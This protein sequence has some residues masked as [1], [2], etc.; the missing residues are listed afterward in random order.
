MEPASTAQPQLRVLVVDDDPLI[1]EAFKRLLEPS[2]VVFAQSAV[3]ALGRIQAG[4][5]FDA[6]LCDINMPGMDG[7]QFHDEVAQRWP[8]LARR[9]V[10]VTG[11][12]GSPDTAAFLRRS[13]NLWL[14]KPVGRD[15]LKGAIAAAA[16]R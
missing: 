11:S 13:R 6:I 3:G 9:I 1:G 7:M 16:E 10:F 15:A 2:R 4:G 14:P 12:S 8:R 5:Q